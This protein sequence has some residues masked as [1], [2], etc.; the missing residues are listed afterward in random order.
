[1]LNEEKGG[2]P[3]HATYKRW[4]GEHK[5]TSA[6]SLAVLLVVVVGLTWANH[7]SS[8]TTISKNPVIANYQKQ[9]PALADAVKKNSNDP[10]ARYD[11]A[12]ALYATGDTAKA[13]DQYE[14]DLKINPNNAV[15][16]NNLGNVY[17]DLGE[18]QQSIDA[19]QKAIS[20]DSKSVN[21]YI[22]L[23]N[24]Y[25]YTLNK[26]DLGVKTFQQALQ[27]LPGNQTIEVLLGVAYEQTGD[28]DSAQQ[29]YNTVLAADPSNVAAQA[30]LKRVR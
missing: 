26:K 10:Q 29:A 24:L 8:K 19:Y 9:L 17:R 15:L 12:V 6:A 16:Q 7:N 14:A 5:R 25:I 3:K 4:I 20:I 13:K 2:E 30:G 22:N 1:M 11:Y 21:P 18:Y 28:K 27:N 23:A